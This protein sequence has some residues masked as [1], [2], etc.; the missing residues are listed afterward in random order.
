MTN[1]K[2]IQTDS[3]VCTIRIMFPI[4][5]DEQAI[6]YKKRIAEVLVDKPE[7]QIHFAISP[8]SAMMPTR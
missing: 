6:S 4:E 2:P 8:M 3:E 1:G 5:S 7:A